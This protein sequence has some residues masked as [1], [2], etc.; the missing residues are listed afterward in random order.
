LVDSLLQAGIDPWVTLYHWDLPQSLYYR[1]G[2]LNREIV[3][4]FADYAAV[5][6]DRLS[7]RVTNW[8]TLNEP[9]VFIGLGME[10]GRHAP[11]DRLGLS[12]VLLAAH[13]AL[14]AHGAA[15]QQIRS[16]SKRACK[17]GWAP[18][19]VTGIPA[20]H[21]A[22]DVAAVRSA[23]FEH[24]HGKLLIGQGDETRIWSNT[25]WSDPVVFGHYPEDAWKA[26]GAAVPKIESGD[27]ETIRQPLDFYGANIYHGP[28][29]QAGA[30]GKP[31]RGV[32]PAAH[33]RTA[34]NWPVSPEVL[35]WGPKLLAERYQLPI[36]VT[37]NGVSC[38]DWVSLDGAV[39]DPSR[40]DFV[41]RYLLELL[42]AMKDGT[43]VRGY[44]LWSI[45]DN[46]E[47]AE[48][49]KE[50]FGI[51]FVDFATQKRIIKDSGRWYAE[52]IRTNA[53]ELISQL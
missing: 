32:P 22:A 8:M 25:W 43:D 52:V 47:W 19:G 38:R 2:W 39:H 20:S 44:F 45:M 14:L 5:V 21:S 17:A 23:M 10:T 11:G 29:I 9:Q 7:D 26:F 48:G 16:R 12:E 31:E 30:D 4:W 49:F 28:V 36:V 6:V 35:Y 37:E 46:F 50:R 42:R 27:M 41:A 33:A 1:G 13:H 51:V 24:A 40:S 3:K 53:A 15:I 34:F 18:V